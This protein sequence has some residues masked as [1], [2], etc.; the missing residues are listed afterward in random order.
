MEENINTSAEYYIGSDFKALV[1]LEAQ[2]FDMDLDDWG[3]TVYIDDKKA[4]TYKKG[5]CVRDD[6]GQYFV[7]VSGDYLKKTGTLKL[8]ATAWI[9]DEDF[10]NGVRRE[11]MPVVIGKYKKL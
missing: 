4:H 5:D 11:V 8:V 7:P 10:P 3:I 9:P 2:G 6:G 1:V